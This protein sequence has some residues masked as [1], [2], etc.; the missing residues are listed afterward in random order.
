MAYSETSICNLALGLIGIGRITDIEGTTAVERDC[1]SI[2]AHA[3]EEVLGGYHWAFA[4]KQAEL[5]RSAVNP[6]IDYAHGGYDYAY[7]LPSDCI[8]PKSLSNPETPFRHLDDDIYCNL[9][10]GVFLEYTANVTDPAKFTSKF[11]NALAHR[12]A[13]Q[14]SMMVKKDKKLSQETWDLYYALLPTLEADDSRSEN[15]DIP[16]SNPYVDSRSV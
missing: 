9:D 16:M 15:S 7:P 13:A 10:E 14:L 11:I 12:L 4:R 1:K 2:F 5:A 6:V 8:S 3:R